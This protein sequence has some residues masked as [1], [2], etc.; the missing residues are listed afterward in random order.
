MNLKSICAKPALLFGLVALAF[1][2]AGPAG[3]KEA[4]YACKC[5]GSKHWIL[6]VPYYD[7]N[8]GNGFM[9]GSDGAIRRH[10]DEEGLG[11]YI[12]PGTARRVI[13]DNECGYYSESG[14]NCGKM[15]G[16]KAPACIH[17]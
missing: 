4:E 9:G 2:W 12:P 10:L 13:N 11:H 16:G 15:I 14:W 17:D 8:C 5:K 7:G 1:A 6:F 3:A